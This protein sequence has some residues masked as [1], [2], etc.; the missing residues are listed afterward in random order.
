MGTNY[1]LF[2]DHDPKHD[3]LTLEDA[4]TYRSVFYQLKS[5]IVRKQ[6][7]ELAAFIREKEKALLVAFPGC[8]NDRVITNLMNHKK[9]VTSLLDEYF[10]W[11]N[12]ELGY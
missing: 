9:I 3:L 8:T 5:I 2:Y 1:D 12:G 10:M 4:N 11:N 6:Q 7:Y